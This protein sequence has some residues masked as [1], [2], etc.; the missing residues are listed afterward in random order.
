MRELPGS[1]YATPGMVGIGAAKLIEESDPDFAGMQVVNASRTAS[2]TKFRAPAFIFNNG[3]YHGDP[4]R[5]PVLCISQ[6]VAPNTVGCAA[7]AMFS[8]NVLDKDDLESGSMYN[9]KAFF[10]SDPESKK[11]FESLSDDACI[12][13]FNYSQVHG[14]A[15]SETSCKVLRAEDAL[16]ADKDAFKVEAIIRKHPWR[17][18]GW[19]RLE[20][21][22][23]LVGDEWVIEDILEL[24]KETNPEIGKLMADI[25]PMPP[26]GLVPMEPS[27][28]SIDRDVM[29]IHG[30]HYAV[31]A[32]PEGISHGLEYT[33]DGETFYALITAA[34][35]PG[36]PVPVLELH[37]RDQMQYTEVTVPESWA[38]DDYELVLGTEEKTLD[39]ACIVRPIVIVH[40]EAYYQVRATP[41]A[42]MPPRTLGP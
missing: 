8:Y 33:E 7:I 20:S 12:V 38:L 24:G 32:T 39:P 18:Q 40:S 4:Y 10:R 41:L 2:I 19:L 36:A 27:F 30:V 23:T 25:E 29:L 42:A 16:G 34:V 11:V 37:S 28:D 9:L 31:G 5:Q 17:S 6:M 3:L 15:G 21:L 35:K 13:D 1:V 22:K 14:F 26:S